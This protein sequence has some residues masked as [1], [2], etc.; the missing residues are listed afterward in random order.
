LSHTALI[1]AFT[2]RASTSTRSRSAPGSNPGVISTTVTLLPSAASSNALA[3]ARPADRRVVVVDHQT[4]GRGRLDRAWVT[5]AGTALTFSAV[6]DPDLPDARW[7][8]L[9]LAAG[10]A[11]AAA[12][13]RAGVEASLKWPNDVLVG[14]RKL[15][16]ILVER[17]EPPA[18]APLA[19]V[20]IGINT[21]LTE[22]ELPVGTATSLAI[23]GAPV[24]R[25]TLLGWVLA[26]LDAALADLRTGPER[27]LGGYREACGTLGRVVD[28]QLPGGS[29]LRGLAG[30]VDDTGR[31]V[32]QPADGPAVAV[33]AG[34]V[35]HVRAAG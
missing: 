29:R 15:A 13:G 21:A 7:P 26:G 34:D 5:P 6:V 20:G 17:V 14:E 35:V 16:G 3:A 31:L 8:L 4:A 32:V 30:T 1:F 24:G 28:V 25:A 19:V 2:C 10:V 11:V 27:F 23:V 22:A 12:V 9:P 18:G 33:G